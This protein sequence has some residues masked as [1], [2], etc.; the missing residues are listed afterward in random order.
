[1]SH[2]AN[3]SKSKDWWEFSVHQRQQQ[4][5]RLSRK[6]GKWKTFYYNRSH[7]HR[8]R[9]RYHSEPEHKNWHIKWVLRG[10][11]GLTVNYKAK[12]K[13]QEWYHKMKQCNHLETLI[14]TQST[15][16]QRVWRRR[17]TRSIYT[18]MKSDGPHQ[19]R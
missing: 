6:R 1:M 7:P 4:Q 9:R 15:P 5:Q 13:Y 2:K 8:C 14:Q 11:M 12:E 19:S 17:R 16:V 10:E 18:M 3:A